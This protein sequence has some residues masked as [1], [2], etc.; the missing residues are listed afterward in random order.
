ML[1]QT[2]KIPPKTP[3]PNMQAPMPYTSPAKARPTKR[4]ALI[5]QRAGTAPLPKRFINTGVKALKSV[6]PRAAIEIAMPLCPDG[7]PNAAARRDRLVKLEEKMM[8]NVKS[9]LQILKKKKNFLRT[10]QNY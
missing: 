4:S 7:M 9:R 10:K 3:M 5:P 6:A 2:E 1:M 8:P